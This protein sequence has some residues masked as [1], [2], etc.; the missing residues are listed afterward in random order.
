MNALRMLLIWL[1]ILAMLAS[2]AVMTIS[3]SAWLLTAPELVGVAAALYGTH[4]TPE[5][6]AAITGGAAAILAGVI[7]GWI[8]KRERR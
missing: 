2:T 6:F 7:A 3:L 1:A 5:V 4:A 8:V